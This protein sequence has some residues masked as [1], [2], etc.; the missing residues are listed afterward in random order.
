MRPFQL[1]AFLLILT[2][3]ASAQGQPAIVDSFKTQLSKA[4]TNDDKFDI[5]GKL[6]RVL[7]NINPAEGDKYG[8]E[9]IKFAEKTRGRRLMIKAQLVNGERY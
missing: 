9:L 3:L 2:V 6:S 7:M 4:T 5:M 1:L 8:N